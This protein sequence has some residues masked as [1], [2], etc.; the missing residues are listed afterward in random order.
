MHFRWNVY[1]INE[2][3]LL[4]VGS[5]L[6]T[7][8][9]TINPK[10]CRMWGTLY[11]YVSANKHAYKRIARR[12]N[13]HS[14]RHQCNFTRGC[15]SATPRTCAL[16]LF[17]FFASTSTFNKFPCRTLDTSALVM[18]GSDDQVLF[19]SQA[20]RLQH[21]NLW[22]PSSSGRSRPAETSRSSSLSSQHCSLAAV[23]PAAQLGPSSPRYR[24]LSAAFGK[25]QN[26]FS[27]FSFFFALL[28][29]SPLAEC[30]D[31]E[32]L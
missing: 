25:R 7:R 26:G 2:L 5:H 3:G 31:R 27:F 14:C 32:R 4:T 16:V 29:S 10:W 9:S 17:F 6:S 12:E 30:A 13:N 11:L 22:Y 28:R 24:T 18:W 23:E 19:I 1:E 15:A 20:M 8:S 21:A